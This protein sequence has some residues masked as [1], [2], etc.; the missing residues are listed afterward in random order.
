MDNAER[1]MRKVVDACADCDICRY[2]LDENCHF[3]P[4]MYSLWDR[5]K[6]TGETITRQELRALADLCNYCA[7]CPCPNIREDIIVAKTAFVDRDGLSPTIRMLEDVARV[8][9]MCGAIPWLANAMLQ[10]KFTGRFVKKCAGI[11]ADRKIPS[12]PR[13]DFPAWAKRCGLQKRASAKHR[14]KVVYFAGC[15]ARYLFPDVARSAVDVLQRNDIAVH[16]PEQHCC[17][18]PSMLEG[19]RNMTLKSARRTLAMLSDAVAD[20]YDVVCSC[21]TCGYML[22]HVLREG[23]YYSSA[24]QDQVGGSD[25]HIKI[26]E[27]PARGPEREGGYK[28]LDKAIYGSILKDDGYF[29]VIDPLKRI[30]VAES[31]YDLGEYLLNRHRQG[32][33]NEKF[34]SIPGRMLYYPPCHQREQEIGA[35]YLELLA[36]IPNISLETM[37]YTADCCG[38]A[39]IM[40]F[41]RDFHDASIQM[42]SRLMDKI[43]SG[44]PDRLVT[45]C[46]S[47]RIQFSQMMDYPVSHPVQLLK[48]AYQI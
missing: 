1:L 23:A 30:R 17:G 4:T 10:G 35:P 28:L 20:G 44:H 19:D 16:C 9:K 14:A 34:G 13:E 31:T 27:K 40:G 42:G 6:E 15:T 21:P 29:S 45:D 41:K 37:Q 46:L 8:G 12:I 7:L 32:K 3:F 18:M 47:C 39:G 25:Q 38:I 22:K 26:P 2:L 33:L 36:L 11:H 43:C 5:E 48:K 24:Y